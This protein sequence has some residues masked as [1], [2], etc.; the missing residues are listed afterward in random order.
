MTQIKWVNRDHFKGRKVSI[1]SLVKEGKVKQVDFPID[2]NLIVCDFCNKDL[3][4]EYGPQDLIPIYTNYAMCKKCFKDL[5]NHLH[6]YLKESLLELDTA[7]I[8]CSFYP[9]DWASV[10]E[11]SKCLRKMRKDQKQLVI[12]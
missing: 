7:K 11:C 9:C 2:D 5:C 6:K 4:V 3:N 12:Q 1:I 8:F 10:K